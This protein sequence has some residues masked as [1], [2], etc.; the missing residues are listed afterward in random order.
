MGLVTLEKLKVLGK[1][2]ETQTL[3]CISSQYRSRG[4]IGHLICIYTQHNHRLDNRLI[5]NISSPTQPISHLFQSLQSV[6]PDLSCG[7]NTTG[8]PKRRHCLC[9][10]PIASL[11][12]VPVSLRLLE[13]IVINTSGA[14]VISCEIRDR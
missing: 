8:V 9:F 10:R 12:V 13:N 1:E 3:H 2:A 7:D 4:G 5:I 14:C 6:N 11:S